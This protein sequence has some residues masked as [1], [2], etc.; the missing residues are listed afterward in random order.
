MSAR[1]DGRLPPAFDRF[2]DGL[3][4][5]LR[6]LRGREIVDLLAVETIMRGDLDLVEAVENVE[7]GQRDAVDAGGLD[8]L[9][10]Q[11]RVEPAAAARTPGVG[12]EFV[13]ALA[14]QP[15][16]FVV[17]FGGKRPAADPG[18]VGLGDA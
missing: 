8:A 7:L 3:D 11:H 14:D 12:A 10:R 15:A 1:P 9:A 16:G 6:G 13:A 2:V 17:E 18:R 4:A 5:R